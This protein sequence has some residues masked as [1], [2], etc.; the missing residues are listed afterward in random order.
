M[1]SALE[2]RDVVRTL[3]APRKPELLVI[4]G[5]GSSSW[6]ITATE[7]NPR[8]FCL[9]G[10]MG[11]AVPMALGLAIARPKN[12][13]LVI[14]GDG[15]ML[16]GMGALATVAQHQPKNL[17]MV[18]LD[19]ELYGETGSQPTHTAGVTDLAAIAAGAGIPQTSTI[20]NESELA[21]ATSA[22]HENDGPA[23]YVVKVSGNMPG[24]VLPPLDGAFAK[25]RFRACILED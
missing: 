11:L 4:G 3:L 13:I 6:D 18:V 23:F 15:D 12:K 21:A 2:R 16:M 1:A 5:I 22:V 8:D 24:T 9:V 14:T 25:D 19:N 20:R 7:E 10:G 17:M